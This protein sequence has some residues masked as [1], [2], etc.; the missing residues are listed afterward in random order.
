MVAITR[1]LAAHFGQRSASLPCVRRNSKAHSTRDDAAYGCPSRMRRQWSTVIY[2]AVSY[3]SVE[4]L[5]DFMKKFA[6]S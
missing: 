1:K 4:H 6:K 2:N 5:V 3:E